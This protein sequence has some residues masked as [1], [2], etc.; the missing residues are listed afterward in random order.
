MKEKQE[1]LQSIQNPEHDYLAFFVC[2]NPVE[3][4]L[5]VYTY[6]MDLRV[7]KTSQLIITIIYACLYRE[8]KALQFSN[9]P[10]DLTLQRPNLRAGSNS[11]TCLQTQKRKTTWG[12]LN[13][14]TRGAIPALLTMMLLSRWK[15]FLQTQGIGILVE[16]LTFSFLFSGKYCQRLVLDDYSQL[17]LTVMAISL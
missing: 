7:R 4:L 1:I 9:C 16:W 8:K 14:I 2:R 6:L 17:M 5:S 13:Q 15:V 12:C 3:K 10:A 11:Y